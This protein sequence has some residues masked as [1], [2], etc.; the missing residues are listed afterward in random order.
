MIIIRFMKF[1]LVLSFVL[2]AFTR[3][4]HLK[5]KTKGNI[6]YKPELIEGFHNSD[7]L[8]AINE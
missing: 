2:A 5:S 1:L 8:K 4:A 7:A 6:D 3:K